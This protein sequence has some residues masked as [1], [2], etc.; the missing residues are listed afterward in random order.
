MTG[1]PLRLQ[2]LLSRAG[3]A[4]R[5]AAEVMIREGRVQVNGRVVREMG[6]KVDPDSDEVMVDG[7]PIRDAEPKVTVVLAK[8]DAVVTTVRD[9]EGRPTVTSLVRDEPYRLVPIGRLDYHTEGV[10]LL[11]TDGELAHRLMH[12][13][14]KVPKAYLVKVGGR[15]TEASLARLRTGVVL[16][17]GRTQPAH[18][19]VVDQTPRR[20]WLEFILTEGRNRQVRR[21]CEAVGHRPLRVVRTAFAGIDVDDLRPGQY[22]YL[23]AGELDGLYRAAKMTRQRPKAPAEVGRARPL[24]KAQRR[25]GALPGEDRRAKRGGAGKPKPRKTLEPKKPP[26]KKPRASPPGVGVRPSD[27]RRR[28]GN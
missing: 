6:T 28:H 21:M 17:D 12:P 13:R 16:E 7:E 3:V 10:L 23:A 26:R 4:S 24:G 14:Y 5:R 1:E 18:V 19:E 9:P 15:P 20:T 25:K 11:T 22:R 8:P 2:K 27:Y